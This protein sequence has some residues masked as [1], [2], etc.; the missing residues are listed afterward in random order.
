MIIQNC[1][2][3]LQELGHIEKYI[4]EVESLLSSLGIDAN[5]EEIITKLVKSKFHNNCSSK[6]GTDIAKK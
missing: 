1:K 3:L 6:M 2:E 4:E 5:Q